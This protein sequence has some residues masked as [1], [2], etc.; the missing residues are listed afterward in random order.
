MKQIAMLRRVEDNL[1]SFIASYRDN[2]IAIV[3]QQVGCGD[4]SL[5]VV[6]DLKTPRFLRGT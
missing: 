3:R 2:S 1:C 6:C 5:L 4:E